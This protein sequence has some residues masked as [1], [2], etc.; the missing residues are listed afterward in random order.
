[1][2]DNNLWM[3]V[4][5]LAKNFLVLWRTSQTSYLH[6]N[7]SV[8]QWF[9]HAKFLFCPVKRQKFSSSHRKTEQITLH[10]YYKINFRTKIVGLFMWTAVKNLCNNLANHSTIKFL[11]S[12]KLT[13]KFT[14]S[15][16]SSKNY[17]LTVIPCTTVE[18]TIP[19]LVACKFHY[20][21]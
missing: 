3:A 18:K 2:I 6:H 13:P 19:F 1:M 8:S 9:F 11:T 7:F 10:K 21:H 5:L 14:L 20:L 16:F 12:Q 15:K 17:T 4:N